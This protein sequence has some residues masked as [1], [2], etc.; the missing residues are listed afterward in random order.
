MIKKLSLSISFMLGLN[1][2]CT[3]SND[4]EVNQKDAPI[5]DCQIQETTEQ[6]SEASSDGISAT[7]WAKLAAFCLSFAATLKV[8]HNQ[9]IIG[10][11]QH[12]D[13]IKVKKL[14]TMHAP[15]FKTAAGEAIPRLSAKHNTI[16]NTYMKIDN[17]KLQ[18]SINDSSALK[19]KIESVAK[20][21]IYVE[22]K[23]YA[24]IKEE[25][26]KNFDRADENL[27]QKTMYVVSCL[28]K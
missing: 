12:R 10:K 14:F 6:C 9:G 8:L 26:D 22:K 20:S 4:Q 27:N 16:N 7:E 19:E 3:A 5:D 11:K 15:K 23:T 2:A 21:M 18:S 13:F 28:T 24:Q 1:L 17:D 25:L